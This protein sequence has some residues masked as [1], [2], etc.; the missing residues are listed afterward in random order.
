MKFSE[1]MSLGL[2][3]IHFMDNVWLGKPV[4]KNIAKECAGC[5]IGAALYAMGERGDVE[6]PVVVMLKHWPKLLALDASEIGCFVCHG[7]PV[8]EK[9]QSS[10]ILDLMTHVATHYQLDETTAEEIADWITTWEPVEG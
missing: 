8:F 3:S 4:N 1:A 2:P 5:L 9:G 6:K 7:W 10:G